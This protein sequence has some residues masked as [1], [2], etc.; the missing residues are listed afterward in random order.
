MRIVAPLKELCSNS[1]EQCV[2]EDILFALCSVADLCSVLLKLRLDEVGRT[3]GDDLVI[4][5]ALVL[6]LLLAAYSIS[7]LRNILLLF[8]SIGWGWLFAMAGV[9]LFCGRCPCSLW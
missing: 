5:D 7:S 8:L 2:G 1:R 4:A 6:I 9:S 3:A